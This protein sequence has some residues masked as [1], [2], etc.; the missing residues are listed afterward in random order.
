MNKKTIVSISTALV[1]AALA[2]CNSQD[3]EKAAPSE[4]NVSN[5]AESVTAPDT[6]VRRSNILAAAES[7]EA[8]TEQAQSAD[9]SK[10]R[11]LV[12]KVQNSSRSVSDSLENVARTALSEQVGRIV[13]AARKND[14]TEVALSA[15]EGY[16]MLVEA[17]PNTDVIPRA[18][19]LLD[20]AG[21]RYQAD[22]AASPIR[23]N[24]SQVA[25]DFALRTAVQN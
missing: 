23:W 19:N 11:D 22:L 17:V 6:D 10:L 8:L 9:T 5:F 3:Q 12:S 18:V 14:R 4:S 16:R 21:F 13:A 25:W 15:V 2:S 20:Y 24:D 1:I 7:F